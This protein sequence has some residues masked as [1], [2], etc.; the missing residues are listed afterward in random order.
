M[1]MSKIE[2]INWI[3]DLHKWEFMSL[4]ILDLMH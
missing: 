1:V 3:L 2:E 4:I